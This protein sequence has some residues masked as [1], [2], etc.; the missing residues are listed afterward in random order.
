MARW[1]L[2]TPLDQAAAR[3]RPAAATLSGDSVSPAPAS[4][5]P[6]SARHG[7]STRAP[8]SRADGPLAAAVAG[9]PAGCTPPPARRGHTGTDCDSR[10]RPQP[11]RRGSASESGSVGWQGSMGRQPKALLQ[12]RQRQPPSVGGSSGAK[13]ASAPAY[14]PPNG[15]PHAAPR[16]R[17]SGPLPC[18]SYTGEPR[19]HDHR[20]CAA[21]TSA[22][23]GAASSGS[24]IDAPRRPV[25]PL[26][27]IALVHRTVSCSMS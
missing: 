7:R 15:R 25:A 20:R 9:G 10:A 18:A 24:G 1:V 13:P 17:A 14:S 5:R 12:R 11:A 23:R 19:C 3:S 27:A 8:C 2:P 26:S 6:R 22:H 16:P 4:G 21:A